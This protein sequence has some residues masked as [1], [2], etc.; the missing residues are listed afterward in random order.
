MYNELNLAPDLTFNAGLIKEGDTW[1]G[2][3]SIFTS[4]SS[5]E[6]EYKCHYVG[7]QQP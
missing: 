1:L 3:V 4:Q 2:I 5:Q 6:Q 7:L